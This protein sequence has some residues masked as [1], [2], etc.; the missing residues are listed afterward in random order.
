M[1]PALCADALGAIQSRRPLCPGRILGVCG[2]RIFSER[3]RALSGRSTKSARGGTGRREVDGTLTRLFTKDTSRLWGVLEEIED[4]DLICVPDLMME[5]VREDRE[6]L[7]E[8]QKQVLK[9]CDEMGDRFAI[10][11]VP[12]PVQSEGNSF[13]QVDMRDYSRSDPALAEVAITE[14][15][16]LRS[17]D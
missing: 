4:A 16:A 11:D 5:S 1:K 7:F 6:N 17:L 14:R 13:A 15:R 2:A 10:L 9:Y 12:P 3:R 8:L